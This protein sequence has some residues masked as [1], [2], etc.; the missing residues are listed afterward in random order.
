MGLFT[1]NVGDV[2]FHV[3]N[4][5]QEQKPE[6]ILINSLVLIFCVSHFHSRSLSFPIIQ[7]SALGYVFLGALEYLWF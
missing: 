5:D 7:K 4:L 2:R 3:I 6:S 1:V